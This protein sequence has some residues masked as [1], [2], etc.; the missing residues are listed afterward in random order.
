MAT[1]FECRL[2]SSPDVEALEDAFVSLSMRSVEKE[3]LVLRIRGLC[4]VGQL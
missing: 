4:S 1:S 3:L 2:V